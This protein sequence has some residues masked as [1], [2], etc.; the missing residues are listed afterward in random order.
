MTSGSARATPEN[1]RSLC[2]NDDEL[3]IDDEI[4]TYQALAKW[5]HQ[6]YRIMRQ[7]LEG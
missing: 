7:L 3:Q 5:I 6:T 2:S 4:I 1:W